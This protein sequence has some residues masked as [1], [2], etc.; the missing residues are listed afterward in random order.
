MKFQVPEL[1]QLL[2]FEAQARQ[3]SFFAA[4]FL[5]VSVTWAFWPSLHGNFLYFDDNAYVISN[6][7]V[8]KGLVPENVFWTFTGVA[9]ANWHPLTW[10]SHMMDVQVYGLKPWGHHL[11]SIILHSL[12]AALAFLV[13][14]KLTGDGWR[15]FV[16]AALFGLH[17]LRV[18]SVAW[19]CERKDVLSALFWLL[20]MWAYAKFAEESKAAGGKWKLFYGLTLL[21]FA[22]GLASKT[23]LVTLPFVLLLLDFWPLQR[24]I[25]SSLWRL[26]LEKIP[27]LLLTIVI[28][29]ISFFAQHG[30][31]MMKELARLPLSD[32]CGNA[33]VSYARYLGKFFWP[34]NLCV[35]YPHPGHW[36]MICILAA[37]LLIASGSVFAW[38][39]RLRR[40]WWLVGWFWFLG[41]LVPVIGLVQVGSQSMADRYTYIPAIGIALILVWECGEL[42]KRLPQGA[43]LIRIAAVTGLVACAALTRHGIGFWQNDIVVWKRAIAVTKNNYAAHD[44]LGMLMANASDGGLDEFQKAVR[45]NPDFEPGQSHLG[46]TL[47]EKGRYPE[48]IDHLQQALKLDPDDYIASYNLALAF[49]QT[50]QTNQAVEWFEKTVSINPAFPDAFYNLGIIYYEIGKTNEAIDAFQ[51]AL[52]LQPH[53]E[54]YYNLGVV[55]LE[56]K[57][58]DEAIANFQEALKLKP[59]FT[60]AQ[61]NLATALKAREATQTTQPAK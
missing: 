54:S 25:T 32:R 6:S 33:L 10:I 53:P 8:N 49:Y 35:L 55:L 61:K 50:R 16:L 47:G 58:T 39:V 44:N 60:A 15:C 48:A 20:A 57:R 46:F 36:P 1:K 3:K 59:D 42:A 40:P 4:A 21:L 22:L 27:F 41:T 45:I 17:P 29:A 56:Q 14:Q 11:T 52:Q 34:E 26:L 31:G 2:S 43:A 12:N 28:S 37:G 13:F 23:M 30:G 9:A 7:H 18:E 24:F 5:F 19:I 51:K 38:A